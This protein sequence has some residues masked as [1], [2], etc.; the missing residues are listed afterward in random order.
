MRLLI[1]SF[2]FSIVST[3]SCFGQ[4]IVFKGR[5]QDTLKKPLAF[6]NVIAEN[7]EKQI[8][9]SISNEN[10]EYKLSLI[11]DKKYDLKVSYLGYKTIDYSFSASKDT[12]YNFT[13]REDNNMI[14]E[15][16]IDVNLAVKIKKDTIVYNTNRFLTGDERKLRDVLKKLPGVE[17]DK[18][19]NV[20]VQGK[21]VTK[22]LVEDKQFFNGDSKLAVNNIPSEVID[23]VEVLD[24]YNDVAILK[25]LE[26]SNDIA[27]NIK[28]KENKKNFWFGDIE[29]GLGIGLSKRH[30]IHPSVFYYSPKTSI[31]IISD[32]NNTGKKSFTFKDYLDF[33][34]GYKK[35]LL[36]PKAYFSKLNDDFSQFLTNQDFKNSNHVF[37]GA[38]INYSINDNTDF[39]GYSIYSKSNNELESRNTN[40]YISNNSL[41]EKRSTINNPVNNFTITKIGIEKKQ[42]DGGKLKINSFF[43]SSDNRNSIET[44]SNFNNETNFIN[45]FSKAVNFD[46]K[47]DLE[48]YKKLHKNHT[49]TSLIN[50]NYNKGD[51]N[52]NWNTNNNTFQDIVPVIDDSDLNIFKNKE[53][54]S[55]NFSALLKHYWVLSNSIHLY[56]TSGLQIVNDTYIT[57][58]FQE[59]SNGELN[60][61]NTS[62]FGNN[63]D[64]N[65]KDIY[66]GSQLKFKKGKFTFKPGLFFHKYTR[67][68]FQVQNRR[69][70]K[71]YLLPELSVDI[72]LKRSEKLKINYSK[73]VRFP[74]ITRLLDNFTLTSFNSVYRGNPSL[75]NELYHQASIYFYKFSFFRKLNYNIRLSYRKSEKG[76]KNSNVLEG[77]NYITQPVLLDNSDENTSL[78]GNI[79]KHYGDYK[80]SLGMSTSFLNYL[81][82]IDN[83]TLKNKSLN[84]GFSSGMKTSFSK[85]P[86]LN[87]SYRKEYNNYETQRTLSRFENDFLDLG[88]EYDF[89][90][91][92]ILNLN[93]NF[94]NFSNKNINSKNQNDLLNI[95]LFYQKENSPWGLE[96]TANNLLDNQFIRNSSFNDF[97]ISDNKKFIL[98]RILLLKIIYKL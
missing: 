39:I 77:I 4:K 91:D 75:E 1:Y 81:Q 34:G 57:D 54:T 23:Q 16:K 30:L 74:T 21:K 96:I 7:E 67:D 53:T 6:A 60:N 52:I 18:I 78:S 95:S 14:E 19:G 87:I 47:Q 37:T 82:Q 66:I 84:F 63:I 43:K 88:I 62:N 93:Y 73:K 31:N 48:W 68:I 94:Q 72:D 36:D 29:A 61:F 32:I 69:L 90:D 98:P 15:V 85:F 89:W 65:F 76:I 40:E 80:F 46:F 8:S 10:G 71:E 33:E 9:F 51:T 35:L 38:N 64:F 58:E 13:L 25:G 45:T 49:L 2:L 12:V 56:T 42:N 5:I 27:M 3:Y 59:T 83:R 41:L 11:R 79:S 24:N 20:T 44:I 50:F 97:L 92:F 86:N 55:L 26:D 22:V 28:L 17:V 70:E